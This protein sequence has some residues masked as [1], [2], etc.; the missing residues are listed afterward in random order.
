MELL[1][2]PHPLLFKPTSKVEDQEFTDQLSIT[3]SNMYDIMVLS[4]GIGLS[5]NQ[6]GIGKS[7]FTMKSEVHGK[8]YIVNPTVVRKSVEIVSHKEGCLSAPG[9]FVQLSERYRWVTIEYCDSTKRK[10]TKTFM[11]ID[12]ICVQHEMD[13]LKGKSFLESKSIPKEDRNRL[14]KKWNLKGGK[15]ER[16]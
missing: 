12:A 8:L 16:E 2:F 7:M 11:G 1:T 3:L 9:E 5:A 6:V 15:H 4:N 13:H 14:A 10:M